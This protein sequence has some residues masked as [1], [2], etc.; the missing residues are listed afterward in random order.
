MLASIMMISGLFGSGFMASGQA[1]AEK[2]GQDSNWVYLI[3]S[4]NK[5]LKNIFGVRHNFDAGFTT[6]L[7]DKQATA[8]ER[9][10][11]GIEKVPL[12]HLTAPPGACSPWPECKNG[13]GD[14]GGDSDSTRL[15]TP[16]DQTPWGIEMIYDD[17]SI[18][19]TSGGSGVNVAVLDTGVAKDHIDL[20][21]RVVDCKDF[22]KGPNPKNKCEDDNGHGTHVSGTI[23]ADG[24][25]DGKG[26]YGVAPEA[27]L[28]AYKVCNTTCWTD[29]IATAIDYAGS[30][31]ANI[32]SMSLGGDTQS[33][34]IRDAIERNPHVLFVA[35][36]G[37]DGP[38]KGSI[39]YPGANTNVLALGAID[40]NKDVP[41]WSS[42]GI[43]DGDGLI[44][45]REVALGA[46][47][48]G[49]YSTWNDGTYNTISGT[50]MATPHA[51][52]LAAKV[53]Q[54]NDEDTRTHLLSLANDIWTSG[55][56]IAT[57]LGLPQVSP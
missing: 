49:V 26:I 14:D 40:K 28:F 52:G 53:W 13:G 37:N 35:A 47:G 43:N 21:N 24:G 2:P 57:G 42:R 22:T 8:L 46:P 45:A 19:S 50:S 48:V 32:V 20:K 12:Y 51:S 55:D 1:F 33:S 9:A 10:G 29:D 17:S 36:A 25:T 4:D 5:N 7:N 34:L 30:H 44:E 6:V 31:G 11:L 15:A 41:T 18:A 16:T 56:D 27:N 39:D 23:L 3:K 54:G 38:D